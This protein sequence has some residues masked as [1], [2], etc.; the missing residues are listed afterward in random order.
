MSIV[1]P[2]IKLPVNQ[3]A[4]NMSLP[5]IPYWIKTEIL[6]LDVILDL[7]GVMVSTLA[8]EAI[9]LKSSPGPN[10]RLSIEILKE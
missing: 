6:I 5:Y 10:K 1:N 7:D 8:K 2:K 3:N 9:N 4:Y